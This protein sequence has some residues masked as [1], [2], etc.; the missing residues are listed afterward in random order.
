M[1]N[2]PNA[3]SFFMRISTMNKQILKG[4]IRNRNF[5]RIDFS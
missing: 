5:I 2:L 3:D 1:N 4:I